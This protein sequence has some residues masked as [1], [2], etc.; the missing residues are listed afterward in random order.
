MEWIELTGKTIDEARDLALEKLGVHESE[1]EVEVLEHP[2]V[3]MFGRVKSMARIRAR[4]APVAAP[5][6]EE[7]RRRGGSGGDSKRSGGRGQDR[8][9]GGNTASETAAAPS[10]APASDKGQDGSPSGDKKERNKN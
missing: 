10:A 1:A 9:G 8:K 3:S 4:V 2:S 6:K 7:R 5:A